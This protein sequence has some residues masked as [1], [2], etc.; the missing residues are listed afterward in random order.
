[1]HNEYE[2]PKFYFNRELSWLEFN[3]RVLE[4]AQDRKNLIFE[5]L[6]FLAI[7]AS[8]LDEFF[9][10]RV[11]GLIDKHDDGVTETDIAG[12]SPAEQLQ[13]ISEKVHD[14]T[15]KQY[16][17]L[18]RS[19]LPTLEKESTFILTYKQLSAKQQDFVKKYFESTVFPILTPMAVD[20]SRPFP[21]LM[22]KSLNIIV[23][24][25]NK[26]DSIFAVVK[27]PT[28]IPRILELPATES[29]RKF[30]FME[31]IIK[32]FIEQLFAGNKVRNSYTF[33]ITRDAEFN[34]GKENANDLLQEI[35]ESIKKRERGV[36][37]RLE[38]EKN[39]SKN[40]LKFLKKRLNL[41]EE[42]IYQISGPIDLT[43][44]FAFTSLEG[45]E[46]LK[47]NSLAPQPVL[48]F[49]NTGVFDAIRKKDILVHHPYDSF[50]CVTNFVKTAANDPKVLAI[51]Q[52]LYR[53]SGRSPI[54][55]ALI[56]AAENGK[57]VTVLVELQARFDEENNILWAKKL[58][59]AGCHVIYGLSGLKTH[60]KICLV[61]RKESDGI[62]RYLHLGTGNYNDSTAKVYTDMGYFTCKESFGKDVSTLFN[63]LTG[64][65]HLKNFQKLAV[66]PRSLKEV[67]LQHIEKETSNAMEGKEAHIIAKM[68]SL[69][70][71]DIIKA[72]Y[73]ASSAGVK[74]KLIIRGICCLRSGMEGISENITVVSIIDRFLEHSRIYYFENRGNPTIFLSSADLMP[75]NLERRVEIAFPIEDENLKQ[76]IIEILNITL[77]DTMKLRVQQSDGTYEKVDRR[78]KE[79]VRSQLLFHTIACKKTEA[80]NLSLIKKENPLV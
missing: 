44:F 9:M 16:S 14:L 46:H 38:V 35:E 76:D 49:E 21:L 12:L 26:E 74:I 27:V 51:K 17:V 57:Q 45:Y 62:H 15:N 20:K 65:S 73:E 36:P 24:L 8:N 31:N 22:N 59:K 42:K 1:M 53:V 43:A 47:N 68:N 61:V 25:E 48:E 11:S 28:V 71:K 50:E 2:N 41:E 63:V 60:C 67:F 32:E 13:K 78:G 75:R 80:Y 55:S 79:A 64:Y 58:E 70:D 77:S 29:K 66:A 23:E 6:K 7:T 56:Q 54:V 37:V 40:C 3:S 19:I 69:V 72:L 34:I 39:I 10:V 52:T 30:I 18:N 5:R 4:E 33:R